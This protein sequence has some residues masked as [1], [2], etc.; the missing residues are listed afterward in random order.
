MK[1][2]GDP[3]R[4]GRDAVF[5]S[6]RRVTFVV[7]SNNAPRRISNAHVSRDP[8]GSMKV[9][10]KPIPAPVPAALGLD[11][12]WSDIADVMAKLDRQSMVLR[13]WNRETGD[14]L[15]ARAVI[16]DKTGYIAAVDADADAGSELIE[17]ERHLFASIKSR[18]AAIAIDLDGL[19][20]P[21]LVSLDSI[22][23]LFNAAI[24]PRVKEGDA[25]AADLGI[26]VT[27][28]VSQ[29]GPAPTADPPETRLVP[30]P[31]SEPQPEPESKQAAAAPGKVP[32][33]EGASRLRA[34]TSPKG[35]PDSL[36]AALVDALRP[37]AVD[38][39][40]ALL[41]QVEY[42]DG[43][44]EYLVGFADSD[45]TRESILETAV[46][47]ALASVPRHSLELG[48]TFMEAG[49]PMVVRISRVGLRLV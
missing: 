21:H 24:A 9:D 44:S 1:R 35:F 37:L 3:G 11:G 19:T 17:I 27:K 41:F 14:D 13:L 5:R 10:V 15:P 33:P 16:L 8:M 7:R 12:D 22:P 26:A 45:P 30:T 4:Q 40:A 38:F 47:S 18:R 48:I 31:L 39:K 29:T 36:Q 42:V 32:Q 6:S 20:S 49:D 23:G 28:S 25:P 2:G 46:N 34:L 43:Q